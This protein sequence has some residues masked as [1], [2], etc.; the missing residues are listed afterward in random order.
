M[1]E[2]KDGTCCATSRSQVRTL[3]LAQSN[4][5]RCGEPDAG[6]SGLAGEWMQNDAKTAL[7][8]RQASLL[9]RQ[10]KLSEARQMY[11][12]VLAQD[13]KNFDA[14]Q[15][16]GLCCLQLGE[17]QSA[18]DLLNRAISLRTDISSVFVHR[19]IAYGRLNQLDKSFADFDKA[20]MLNPGAADAHY[21]RGNL[22][23]SLGRLEEAAR[24]YRKAASLDPTRTEYLNNLGGVLQALHRHAEA[25][26]CY[27][28]IIAN[29][30][31]SVT[32][33]YNCGKVLHDMER[34]KSAAE[35][36]YRVL[37]LKSDH[38]D[39][40]NNL[41][42]VLHKLR[43]LPEAL[44]S[45]SL[46]V[47]LRPDV[48]EAHSNLGNVLK[49][50]N[51][52]AEAKDSYSMALYLKPGMREAKLGVASV[53]AELGN[54][55][56]A[57]SIYRELLKNDPSD[58]SSLCGLSKT[59]KAEP[60]DPLF[61]A[62]ESRLADTSTPTIARSHLLH[63]YSKICND[64]LRF[65]DAF[66][67]LV[68]AKA[69]LDL[70]FD[71]ARHR[72]Y[73][74]ELKALF[75]PSFFEGRK[76]WGVSDQ[77][78]V[79][80]VGMPRSG[81]TLLEQILSGHSQVVGLGE[82]AQM[83]LAARQLGMDSGNSTRFSESVLSMDSTDVKQAAELY[84]R[85]YE[86]LP[87]AGIRLIDKMPHNFQHLGLI[88]LLF[89][90]AHIIHCIRNPIDNCLSIFM[91]SF[92][93]RHSY[94]ADLTT[95]GQYHRCYQE[96]MAHWRSALPMTIH[97]CHYEAV[98]N[99][100]EKAAKEAISYLGLQWEPGCLEHQE[101]SRPVRTA[102]RWQVRQPVYKTSVERW[103]NFE[104]HL[105]PLKDSLGID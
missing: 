59:R 90:N 50:L 77:R 20:L 89:P 65:D 44:S 19:G 63:S 57:E 84:C 14:L 66:K 70:N 95:L 64:V 16:S 58:V 41:G 97:E 23:R 73:L 37:A 91:Q 48:A 27:Q 99:D 6:S 81:T 98:V 34:Y 69:L 103:R 78:P 47:K 54:F 5:I 24:D 15:L 25:L 51:R 9:H 74:D 71:M 49:D 42:L 11:A 105:G 100:A 3:P 22:L 28:T 8:L 40:L 53:A 7:S 68:A 35:M 67:S 56:E 102:S 94:A 76:G 88:A 10:G 46:A 104:K 79:F 21:N 36:Y 93:D 82:L 33:L 96:L 75:S 29:D 4:V 39:A 60:E 92:E 52:T 87:R 45:L 17:L 13:K 83:N 62:I 80:I 18:V 32:A 2:K 43:I 12:Q 26:T 38:F 101:R 30:S 86:N 61:A 85:A 31:T 72:A 1:G 55:E